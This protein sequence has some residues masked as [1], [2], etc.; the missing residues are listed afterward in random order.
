[1][2]RFCPGIAL[3]RIDTQPGLTDDDAHRSAPPA[4]A[5]G[6]SGGRYS[7][8]VTVELRFRRPDLVVPDPYA[9]VFKFFSKDASSVGP[10]AYDSYIAGGNSPAN[11]IV[12]DDVVA[13]NRTMRAR[14]SHTRWMAVIERGDL[15]ELASVD[16]GWDAF[17]TPDDEWEQAEVLGRIASLVDAIL[18]PGVGVSVATKALHIKRPALIPI[19]DSYVL[20]L[21]GIPGITG[22]SAAA[23]IQHLRDTREELL[24]V[25]D[26]LQARLRAVGIDRSLVRIMDVLIWG[27][28]PDTWLYRAGSASG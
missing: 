28:H 15:P 27:S 13:I 21:M 26:D 17:L 23:L 7:A 8:G 25:L 5:A 12:L 22:A 4:Q 19:C 1:L 18:G 14:S 2:A 3:C 16:P 10:Y 20:Q 24:P 6:R 9:L 11:R